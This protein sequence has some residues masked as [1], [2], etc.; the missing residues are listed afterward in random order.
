[1]LLCSLFSRIA[2]YCR[3]WAN[4]VFIEVQA[5]QKALHTISELA[6]FYSVTI[7]SDEE[8]ESDAT[9]VLL[10]EKTVDDYMDQLLAEWGMDWQRVLKLGM[11]HMQAQPQQAGAKRAGDASSR[12]EKKKIRGGPEE[13]SD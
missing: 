3:D 6:K 11:Q 4:I 5:T 8:S 13:E 1:M 2:S 7:W 10:Q 12:G 9:A